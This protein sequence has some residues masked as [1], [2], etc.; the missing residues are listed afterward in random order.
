[1]YLLAGL[2]LVNYQFYGDS[3]DPQVSILGPTLFVLFLN[4]IMSGLSTGTNIVMY[5]GDTKIWTQM[6]CLD[7][8]ITLPRDDTQWETTY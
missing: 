1:M 4:D 2:L 3:G 6:E 5:A 8:R 7:D